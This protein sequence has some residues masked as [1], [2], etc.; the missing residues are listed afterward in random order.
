[1]LRT[2]W[3]SATLTTSWPGGRLLFGVEKADRAVMVISVCPRHWAEDV[4]RLTLGCPG[5]FHSQSTGGIGKPLEKDPFAPKRKKLKCLFV[6]LFEVYLFILRESV[7]AHTSGGRA[8]KEGDRSPE[9]G[10]GAQT[11]KP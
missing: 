6:C 1:M 5:P 7:R 9:S 4:L 11:H 2:Q 8:E 3:P 10:R